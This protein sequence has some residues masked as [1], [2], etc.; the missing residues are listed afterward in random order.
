MRCYTTHSVNR[1]N[2]IFWHSMGA[3]GIKTILHGL[4]SILPGDLSSHERFKLSMLGQSMRTFFEY[5]TCR[6]FAMCSTAS[7]RC[8]IA[9][10]ARQLPKKRA[11]VAHSGH[12]SCIPTGMVEPITFSTCEQGLR[13]CRGAHCT[14]NVV[15]IFPVSC[16]L[17][18]PQQPSFLFPISTSIR[19][20]R[21]W[22]E[23][24]RSRSKRE[25]RCYITSV[26]FFSCLSN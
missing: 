9:N 15:T 5:Q 7:T 17:I 22:N 20:E 6:S 24:F 14:V 1:H 8:A 19:R 4:L 16:L 13:C 12:P 26:S 23:R 11:L 3:V 21:V 2:D 18:E 10:I 25:L